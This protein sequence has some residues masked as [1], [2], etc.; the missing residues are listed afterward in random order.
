MSVDER[1]GSRIDPAA[2]SSEYFLE[3]AEGH[4]EYRASGGKLLTAR[5]ARALELADPRPGE[6]MLDVACGRGELVLHGA[7]RGAQTLG[8]DF[9]PAALD[10]AQR[11]VERGRD[12]APAGL[13]L[14]DAGRLGLRGEAFDVVLMLDFVEHVRQG[15]LEGALREA[16]RALRPGGRL[17]IH[18]SPNRLFERVVYPHYVRNVHRLLL[19]AARRLRLE[20]R[21]FNEI[22]MP[23][24]P[25]PPH[26]E[27]E[28][29]LHVNPQS[30]DSLCRSLA[31]QGFRMRHVDFWEPPHGTFFDPRLR[32]HNFLVAALDVVRFLRPFSRLPPLNRLFSNH[33]WV[34]AER[35]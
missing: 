14:M 4:E 27:Y 29:R 12:G 5:L 22:V 13:A 3:A 11:S 21:F 15:E 2:Y 26:G 35:E 25:L 23:T 1:L 31:G 33:I 6:R 17:V 20:G 9:A 8:I 16:R 18:T 34:V 30:A 32:W 28:R 7:L 24:D 19:G 10:L